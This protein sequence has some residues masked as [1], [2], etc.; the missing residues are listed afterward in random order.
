M[1]VDPSVRH[2]PK[3]AEVAEGCEP[4][5][6]CQLCRRR[7]SLEQLQDEECPGRSAVQ[8]RILLESTPEKGKQGAA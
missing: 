2:V 1:T 5:Y 8:R 6:R 7:G 3:L 4:V